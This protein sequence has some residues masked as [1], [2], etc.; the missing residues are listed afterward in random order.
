MN[1]IYV[2]L[3]NSIALLCCIYTTVKMQVF[4]KFTLYVGIVYLNLLGK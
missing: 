1:K 2:T 4:G 3:S